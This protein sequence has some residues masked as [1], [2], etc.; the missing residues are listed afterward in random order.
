LLAA[1]QLLVAAII[2]TPAIITATFG[3]TEPRLFQ[4]PSVET[5]LALFALGAGTIG[6]GYSLNYRLLLE[7]GP[8]RTSV[9]TY[10]IPVVAVCLGIVLL[11]EAATW[12]LFVG[13]LIV[14]MGVAM[15]EG[16]RREPPRGEATPSRSAAKHEETPVW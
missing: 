1:G 11:G 8:V 5:L 6:F 15:T 7:I 4:A 10:L 2:L 16:A 12:N 3:S 13:G 9:V 14:V